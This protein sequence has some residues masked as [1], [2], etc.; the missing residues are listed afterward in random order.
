[1]TDQEIFQ[2]IAEL[3]NQGNAVCLATIVEAAI[4]LK[5]QIFADPN[6]NFER[7]LFLLNGVNNID[8]IADEAEEVGDRLS[9]YSIKRAL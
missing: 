2:K 7:K 8:Q 4:R 1:M 9:I 6:L 3:Q 5:K